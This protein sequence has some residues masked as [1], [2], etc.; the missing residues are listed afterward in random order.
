MIGAL[1]QATN[2]THDCVIASNCRLTVWALVAI[3]KG[4]ASYSSHDLRGNPTWKVTSM[5]SFGFMYATDC[6]RFAIDC[7]RGAPTCSD[8]SDDIMGPLTL[9]LQQYYSLGTC[10]TCLSLQRLHVVYHVIMHVGMQ[11][12]VWPW[13][14]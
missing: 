10:A 11:R 2:A 7:N 5:P 6:C 13:Q 1:D 4:S 14:P 3:E 9:Q 12:Q 8:I